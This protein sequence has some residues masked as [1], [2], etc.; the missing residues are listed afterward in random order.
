MRWTSVPFLL[1]LLVDAA[2]A[3][4]QTSSAADPVLFTRAAFSF[5][6]AGLSSPDPR[7]TW[8]AR[9]RVD[10]DVL[11]TPRWRLGFLTDY[12][13]VIG[14]ERR[15]FDLNQGTYVFEGTASRHLGSTE[16]SFVAKHV[17]RHLTDREQ[18]PSISWNYAGARVAHEHHAGR[19][20]FTGALSLGRAMQPAFVDYLWTSD[21]QVMFRYE[22]SPR[23][24]WIAR[25]DGSVI[26][27]I[28]Q[29]ARR[30]R[31]CG[32][33]VEGAIRVNGQ[34][35]AVELFVGYERRMDGFPTDR[36]RVRF[37]SLGFRLLSR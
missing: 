37:F 14:S 36:F 18:G 28:R 13:V 21:L 27:T 24:E 31:I 11:D 26:G 22:G 2:P 5:E 1:A 6:W 34:V 4:A 7:F 32:G 30:P 12:N 35:A 17:S 10:L 16:L 3:G 8:D 25:A 9:V 29:V 33:R 23:V 19:S 15:P 20:H